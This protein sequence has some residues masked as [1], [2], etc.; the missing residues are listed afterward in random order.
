MTIAATRNPMSIKRFAQRAIE[1]Q[2][3]PAAAAY[4]AAAA[5]MAPLY[6]LA[7]RARNRSFDRHPEKAI[8]L[9][10]PTI[11]I[12][13]LSAGGTGK[14]PAT[15]WLC[16]KLIERGLRPAVLMRGYGADEPEMI[17]SSVDGVVVAA[18]PDRASAAR[19]VLMDHADT[20]CF[21]LDDGFQH[22]RAARDFDL[23]LVSATQMGT[24]AQLLPRG[25]LRESFDSLSRAT[26]VLITKHD[27]VPAEQLADIERTIRAHTG[28]P[29]FRSR[30]AFPAGIVDAF[31]L[32]A[33]R[34]FAVAGIGD[35]ASFDTL[36]RSIGPTYAG[37]RWFEDHHA[38]TE[39]DLRL[40]NAEARACGASAVVT[41]AK[42]WVKI[43]KF[44]DKG[45]EKTTWCPIDV[46]LC[47]DTGHESQLIE[48]MLSAVKP[49]I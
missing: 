38:Y 41:T 42:D 22:R 45:T 48:Q 47:F 40:I 34:F 12:G 25:L 20:S 24:Q 18:D 30:H 4:R 21:V 3:T 35:P 37:H 43:R 6:G 27:A 44:I 16:K 8:S 39:T 31:N 23:V 9:G 46:E 17:R 28:V 1:G 13:N 2:Q 7:V 26:A 36:L 32:R 19:R 10:R 5:V 11:S 14:T 29:I 33:T 49:K 15:I